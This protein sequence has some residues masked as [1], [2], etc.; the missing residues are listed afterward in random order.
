MARKKKNPATSP[1]VHVY[2]SIGA[3]DLAVEKIREAAAAATGAAS[4]AAAQSV[5]DL[6]NLP[7]KAREAA[8]RLVERGADRGRE[9]ARPRPSR[10]V[11]TSRRSPA[12][13]RRMRSWPSAVKRS[14]AGCAS[15]RPPPRR[16]NR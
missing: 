4:K 6:G 5:A 12:P 7:A 9:G 14:P 2:A 15:R 3:T 8:A 13:A 1:E 11:P 16:R 10:P